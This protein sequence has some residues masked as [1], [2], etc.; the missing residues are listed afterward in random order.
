M[1]LDSSPEA[2]GRA[3]NPSD[4]LD[5]WKQVAAHLHRDVSTV[6]RWERKEGLPIHRH[7]HDKLGSIYA[8]RHELDAWQRGR[9]P[10]LERLDAGPVAEIAI[11]SSRPRRRIPA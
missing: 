11:G 10:Q 6:Q 7:L 1:A 3:D 8:F 5:S 2:L 4:R 9:G